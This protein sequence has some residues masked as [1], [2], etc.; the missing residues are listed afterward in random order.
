MPR[1]FIAVLALP[2]CLAA[3]PGQE[4]RTCV[5]EG[6]V[7]DASTGQGLRG[8]SVAAFPPETRDGRMSSQAVRTSDSEGHFRMEGLPPGRYRLSMGSPD[9]Q[10]VRQG[11]FWLPPL[12]AGQ[13]LG[14]LRIEMTSFASVSGRVLDDNGE[15]VSGATVELRSAHGGRLVSDG[16]SAATNDRG[17]FLITHARPGRYV[18]S[19][20]HVESR[21]I[22]Y[23][24]RG[25]GIS[26]YVTT[27][28][29][30][31]SEVDQAQWLDLQ[32]GAEQSGLEIQLRREAVY[33]VRGVAVDES[34]APVPRFTIN[35][36]SG[37]RLVPLQNRTYQNGLF[38]I[39]GLRPGL[40]TLWVRAVTTGEPGLT[41]RVAL[42]VG[43]GGVENLQVR[44]NA[45]V[46]LAGAAV[47]E[48]ADAGQPDWT[49]V[50]L[51][52]AQSD[53]NVAR[54]ERIEN[55]ATFSFDIADRAP[56]V[57][58]SEG[59][60]LPGAYLAA[61]RA[62]G[63]TLSGRTIDLSSGSPGPLRLIFRIGTAKLTGR[64]EDSRG[65]AP[66]ANVCAHVLT[67]KTD[68]APLAS[69]CANY[70]G[71]FAFP[72][73]PP[74][75]YLVFAAPETRDA[76]PAVPAD[77]DSRAVRIHLSGGSTQTVRLTLPEGPAQ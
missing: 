32:P 1:L 37:E 10:P 7:V 26:A 24:V 3:Q 71:S 58:R 12:E 36:V 20:N 53:G 60:P 73:L 15:P 45:P 40:Y 68:P 22:L 5:I 74:G 16:G 51:T 48:P 55:D 18:L 63:Q 31:V 67:A 56:T 61:I 19:A 44:L 64:V 21:N 65:L 54:A 72:A 34:G 11:I 46:H 70:D 49:Q 38:E 50:R 69:M 33:R 52:A 8:V 2:L 13:T 28:L 35:V 42:T 62:G 59:E 66:A 76:A 41:G 39:E 25:G 75:D 17:D 43:R 27:F 29:P 47:L 23:P 4:R 57:L 30:G 6:T 77:V 14:G 9:L